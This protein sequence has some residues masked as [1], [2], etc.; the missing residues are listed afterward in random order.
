MRR[1][2]L[3]FAEVADSFNVISKP[4][5]RF[6]DRSRSVGHMDTIPGRLAFCPD[7]AFSVPDSVRMVSNARDG[8]P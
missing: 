4:P 8:D 1:W 5:E 2:R 6:T 7:S 3:R